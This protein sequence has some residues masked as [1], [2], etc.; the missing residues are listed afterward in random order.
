MIKKSTTIKKIKGNVL[1]QVLIATCLFALV[2]NPE[3]YTFV[4]LNG[5]TTW[6]TILVPAL[7]PF[8]VFSSLFGKTEIVKY[9]SKKSS[10]LTNV[11]FN[12]PGKS[13]YI[14]L[15]SIM[16]GY[17]VG[18]KLVADLY[19][20]GQI[21]KGQAFRT[22]SFTSNS[23]P[24]FILGTVGIGFL[25]SATAGYIMLLSH[26]IG[27]VINGLIYRKFRLW[28]NETKTN[29][30]I[31]VDEKTSIN[32]TMWNSIFPILIIGAFVCL[33]F[34]ISQIAIDIKL[35]YPLEIIF[36][37]FGVEKEVTDS[38]LSGLLEITKGTKDISSTNLSLTLKTII[39]CFII[40]FGGI[41]TFF[42]GYAFLEKIGISK[43][44]FIIQKT[45]HA[46]FATAVCVILSLIFL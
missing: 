23:G 24:M 22:T 27:A 37:K 35:F 44:F 5:I 38:F 11:L 6:S 13:G 4:S 26:A 14:Y 45:A 12:C 43:R 42:Q 40:S 9:L 20:S 7:F 3:K 28:D 2:I 34:I 25:G 36:E 31:H 16:S 8:F 15:I 33:F 29:N 41:A 18:S 39:S 32:D 30:F 46:L 10:K 19:M 21:S 1:M 17:P